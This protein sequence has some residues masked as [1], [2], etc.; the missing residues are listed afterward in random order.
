MRVVMVVIAARPCMALLAGPRGRVGAR[1]RLEGRIDR[2][3][4]QVHLVEHPGQHVVGFELEV[5]GPQLQLRM[6]VA[7]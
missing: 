4:D 1:L 6:A 3:H 5:I 2:V 7:G